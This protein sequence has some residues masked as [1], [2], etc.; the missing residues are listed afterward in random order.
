M[1]A[2]SAHWALQRYAKN[3]NKEFKP[4]PNPK[5]M[6]AVLYK[7]G[8]LVAIRYFDQS[9]LYFHR[10]ERNLL[11][12]LEA[13]REEDWERTHSIPNKIIYSNMKRWV[14]SLDLESGRLTSL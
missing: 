9:I 6:Q 5:T 12:K 14:S 1:K 2:F 10:D 4:K 8:Q 3:I 7:D 13:K 11:S